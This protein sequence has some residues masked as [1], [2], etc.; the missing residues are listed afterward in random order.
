MLRQAALV[1]FEPGW[2]AHLMSIAR[3]AAAAPRSTHASGSTAAGTRGG[4]CRRAYIQNHFGEAPADCRSG[5][6]GGGEGG[7]D[8]KVE[9][10]IEDYE[11]CRPVPC[12]P[13]PCRPV[14]CRPV[15][16]RPE[17]CR[18]VQNPAGQYPA[19]QYPAGQNPAGQYPA[20]QPIQ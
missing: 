5:R 10:M 19:G 3:Y 1:C 8:Y 14:P 2:A 15:P 11:P 4:A 20:G 17:P 12:R 7:R 6:E 16:C 18:P 9:S 13:E